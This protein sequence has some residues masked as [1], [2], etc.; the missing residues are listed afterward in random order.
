M[1]FFLFVPPLI[2]S[3]CIDAHQLLCAIAYFVYRKTRETSRFP[4]RLL[5]EENGIEATGSLSTFPE[6]VRI[7][8]QI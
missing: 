6:L 1:R 2:L 4:T 8:I 7:F 5:L 3:T